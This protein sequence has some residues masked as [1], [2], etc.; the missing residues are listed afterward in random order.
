MAKIK[1]HINDQVQVLA[2]KDRGKKGKVM[3]V[4]RA[5]NLVVVE[6]VNT[7]YKYIKAQRKS[8]SGQ[9]VEF[10][11]PIHVSNVKLL[12]AAVREAKPAS[13]KEAKKA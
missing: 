8:D 7:M 12:E 3:Q 11:G 4:L 10:F 6:G 1:L 2:G 13:A 9:R 5:D